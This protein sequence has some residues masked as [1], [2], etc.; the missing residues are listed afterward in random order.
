MVMEE[1]LADFSDEPLRPPL[2]PLPAGGRIRVP[3][4][5]VHQPI[6]LP[7][8]S[9]PVPDR[10]SLE[11]PTAEIS[12]AAARAAKM[13]SRKGKAPFLKWTLPDPYEHRR[14]QQITA[15]PESAQPVTGTPRTP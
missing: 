1:P 8:R 13:P 11:D 3:S 6:P 14:P 15:P 12:T 7:I 9:Q 2:P 5:D 4:V 10:A